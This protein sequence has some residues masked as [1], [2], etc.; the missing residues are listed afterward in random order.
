MILGLTSLEDHN[1]MRKGF[2]PPATLKVQQKTLT[3]ANASR[4]V[5]RT[6]NELTSA[7]EDDGR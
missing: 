4:Y 5:A 2:S 6:V 1:A 7:D 3:S